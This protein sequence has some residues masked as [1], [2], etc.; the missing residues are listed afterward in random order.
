[1]SRGPDA[2]ARLERALVEAAREMGIGAEV[3]AA[4]RVRW[5]SATFVGA[6]HR[7]TLSAASGPA[8]D[9]WLAALPEHEFDLSGHL[10]ADLV[11]DAIRRMGDRAEIEI[12]VLTVEVA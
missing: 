3:A 4:D 7:L 11:I 6:R 1:M 8:L 12:E 9:A 5:A 10:V 2:G